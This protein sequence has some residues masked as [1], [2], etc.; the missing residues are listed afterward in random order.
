MVLVTAVGSVLAADGP[1][2][3]S[4]AKQRDFTGGLGLWHGGGFP[5]ADRDVPASSAAWGGGSIGYYWSD[6]LK[7]EMQVGRTSRHSVFMSVLAAAPTY[8]KDDGRTTNVTLGQSYQFRL[9]AWW[10][11]EVTAGIELDWEH[12]R[13]ETVVYGGPVTSRGTKSPTGAYVVSSTLRHQERVLSVRPFIGTGFKRY[14]SQRMF[15]RFAAQAS[16]R[17]GIDNTSARLGLG[18]DF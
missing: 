16:G 6:H 10:H 13:E 7:S 15:V 14:L 9:N 3:A 2:S 4:R 12:R 17:R 1:R 18:L 8:M 11:P 5:A